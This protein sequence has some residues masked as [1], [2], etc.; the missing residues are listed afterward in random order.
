MFC[1]VLTTMEA[2]SAASL[3]GSWKKTKWISFVGCF[4]GSLATFMHSFASSIF[5]YQK[6]EKKTP[7]TPQAHKSKLHD[8]A[9]KYCI[10]VA[11]AHAANSTVQNQK[12]SW[13]ISSFF[14]YLRPVQCMSS[15][16]LLRNKEVWTFY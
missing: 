12:K 8:M 9:S 1:L 10:H 11:L 13:P 16:E 6:Q 4:F 7:E 14:Y 5:L 3:G 2:T 15:N